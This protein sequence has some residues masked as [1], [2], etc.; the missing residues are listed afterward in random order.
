MNTIRE[1][2]EADLE[3][4]EELHDFHYDYLFEIKENILTGYC[5]KI[6]NGYNI[7]IGKIKK[8]AINQNQ[9]VCNKSK[10][11]LHYRKLQLY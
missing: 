3:C 10:C 5:K 9:N 11:L 1:A 7:S 6:A 8:L 2:L 4:P